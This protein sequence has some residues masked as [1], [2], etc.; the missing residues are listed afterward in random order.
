MPAKIVALLAF[1]SAVFAQAP[2]A[3]KRAHRWW[4]DRPPGMR[5]YAAD[6]R[7]MPLISVKGNKFVDPQ[8]NTVLF[9]G[10]AIADPD[11]LEMDGHWN[12]ELFVKVKEMGARVVRIPVHPVAWR[13]RTPAEYLKLLD[14]AVDWCT[15]LELYIDL[16]W[17]SI[18]NLPRGLFQDPMYDTSEQETFG[19]WRTAAR[20]Y[21]GHNTIAFFELFNEPTTFFDKLG[22]ASWEE[23]K[24]INE[25]LITMIRAYNVQAIPLV[26]G[27]DWAYDLTPLRLG[28]LAAEGIG[29]SVHPYANKRP[30]PWEGRWEED[31]GF[32]AAKYPVVAT[33][34]GGFPPAPAPY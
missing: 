25:D 32:A 24:K 8:G 15:E 3:E 30:Q 33:E 29:Y 6:A 11:K 31:F 12:R 20:H 18:G 19:F 7:K 22:P 16:D 9:R 34:F 28:P 27:F 14:Q 1:A 13:E 21:A 4:T 17:H 23:W 2:P 5:A 26:A 10:V